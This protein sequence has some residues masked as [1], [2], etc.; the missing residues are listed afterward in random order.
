[1]PRTRARVKPSLLISSAKAV[2]SRHS[3]SVV[4]VS[5]SQPSQRAS[6]A[7]VQSEASR[8]QRRATFLF[9]RQSSSAA[10][11]ATASSP[12][13]VCVSRVE[14]SDMVEPLS[15]SGGGKIN[16]GFRELAEPIEVKPEKGRS[17]Q[18]PGGRWRYGWRWRNS[19]TTS[20][21]SRCCPSTAWFM[22]RMSASEMVPASFSR[23]GRRAGYFPSVARRTMGTASYG[24]K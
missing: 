8:A 9:W 7:P 6:S 16:R 5:S 17:S 15:H 10:R 14:C 3:V 20:A 4:R 1:M 21:T 13:R 12:G 18:R 23:A 24:G 22:R 19:R 11:T 2:S